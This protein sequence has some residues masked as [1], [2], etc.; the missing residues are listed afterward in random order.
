MGIF[1]KKLEIGQILMLEIVRR[2]VTVAFIE[3]RYFV[4][5][6]PDTCDMSLL[7]ESLFSDQFLRARFDFDVFRPDIDNDTADGG[8]KWS[9]SHARRCA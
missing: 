7:P 8:P 6:D 1:C 2:V 3:R 9:H 4:Q 5:L